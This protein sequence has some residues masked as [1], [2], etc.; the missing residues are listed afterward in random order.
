MAKTFGTSNPQSFADF[1]SDPQEEVVVTDS[2]T[3]PTLPSVTVSDIPVGAAIVRVAAMFK[4]R[5]VENTNAAANKLSGTTVAATSQVIQVRSDAPGTWTDAIKFVD[6]Q[7][8]VAA[9]TREGGDVLI[10][11]IDIAGEVDTNDTYEFQWLCAL[12]DVAI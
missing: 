12:A 1:W 9:S 8:G 11:S 2:A 6:D 4:F 5:A 7:F 10:G 3:T